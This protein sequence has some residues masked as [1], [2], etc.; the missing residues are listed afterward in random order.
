VSTLQPAA[1]DSPKTAMRTG[2]RN[3][4]PTVPLVG[5]VAGE[6]ILIVER[7]HIPC[8]TT[9]GSRSEFTRSPLGAQGI[10]G[11]PAP[12]GEIHPQCLQQYHESTIR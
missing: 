5:P 10:D 12:T 3:G 4:F 9:M 7:I 6:A 8:A 2:G 1:V 11:R